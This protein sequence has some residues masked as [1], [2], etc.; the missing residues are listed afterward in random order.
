MGRAV[1]GIV[2]GAIG[3]V[4]MLVWVVLAVVGRR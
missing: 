2:T 1:F 3:T 4:A